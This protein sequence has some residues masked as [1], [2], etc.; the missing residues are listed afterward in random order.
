MSS[1][2]EVVAGAA[3]QVLYQLEAGEDANRRR[4]MADAIAEEALISH[5]G[6]VG[7][8]VRVAIAA[9]FSMADNAG[10]DA[11]RQASL[12]GRYDGAY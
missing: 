9:A 7:R 1:D 10:Y 5:G 12:S 6:D 4:D 8:A 3:Q 2:H 11:R